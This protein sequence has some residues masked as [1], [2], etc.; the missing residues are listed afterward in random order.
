VAASEATEGS[1][2][3]ITR[4]GSDLDEARQQL[5]ATTE[6]LLTV[7]Q[8]ASD[9]AGVLR[10]VVESARRLIRAEIAQIHLIEDRRYRLA[11]STGHSKE[12]LDFVADHPIALDRQTLIGR[13]GVD[14][15]AQQIADVL[16]D[17][18][19]G[20]RDIQEVGGYRSI[21]GV[22]M[23][24]DDEVVGVLSAWRNEV[25]PFPAR[26]IEV[27]TTFAAQAAI[28]IRNAELVSALEARGSELSAKVEQLEALGE[29]GQAVTSSLDL[30]QVLTKIVTH[31][32]ELT[33]A[34]GGSVFEFDEF[35]E[36][37]HVRTTYG[38]SAD[39]AEALRVIHMKL[40][41]TLVGRAALERK[42][43]QIPD[44]RLVDCDPHLQVLLEG[45]W[46]SVIA[47]PILRDHQIIGAL[48][49]RRKSV[50][51]F[52]D[53]AGE[54][55]ETFAGQSAVAII[56]ARLFA[57]LERKSAQLEV[58]SR[59]KSEFLASMSHELR[60]PLNAVIGF[61]DVLLERLYG[62]INE[63][64][65]EYL[66]D[67][68]SS[69]RHLLEILNDILDISKIEADRLELDYARFD[70]RLLLE[71]CLQMVREG[72]AKKGLA[73]SLVVD[74]NVDT[75]VADEL[76]IRQVV[77][78]LLSNAVKFSRTRIDVRAG[79][80]VGHLTV[81]VSDDGPGIALEYQSLIFEAFQ[82]GKR[83]S[84]EE[85]TGLGLTVSRQLVEKHGGS[86][87]VE[88]ELGRGSTFTFMVPT[89]PLYE[90]SGVPAV[91]LPMPSGPVVVV[92]ED[93]PR[94]LEL[95]CL[96]VRRLGVEYLTARDGRA[97]LELIRRVGPTAVILDIQLPVLDGWDLLGV[98]KGDPATAKIP[99]VVVSMLDERGRGLALGAAEYLVKPVRG[100][101][102][103]AALA[104]VTGLPASGRKLVFIGEDTEVL[105]LLRAALEPEGW[106]VAGA[107][108]ES[109]GLRLLREVQPAV[110]LLDLLGTGTSGLPMVD[111]V[112]SD[113][114][115]AGVPIIVLTSQSMTAEEK[116]RLRGQIDLVNRSS[117]FDVS[118]LVEV[119]NRAMH[120]LVPTEDA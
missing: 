70:V 32:V 3:E 93:D 80:D 89:E 28:V 40:R 100:E 24:L 77:L 111:S 56:N 82:Q 67:I 22:P 75:V 103:R 109:E 37:F 18:E 6:V 35:D 58:A 79:S 15:R 34:D 49:I 74:D 51:G 63:K 20:R 7:G 12:Y 2:G 52:A 61:S 72:A 94:S 53:E 30:D 8:S 4:L 59:H 45:G 33:D 114:S 81:Q 90:S 97:G 106:I 96:H 112:R 31:A 9:S 5:A 26:A 25:D 50:G 99:V 84:R 87:T 107:S 43:L 57:E 85:G 120:R 88:S 27:L 60:T 13:V 98:L 47:V 16:A 42:W 41:E 10:S 11:S 91:E 36:E 113:P 71:H 64:Q 92:V 14:R 83:P 19:Y 86:L 62:D 118:A 95:L 119:V 110:V 73:I 44:L 76:R 101:D 117:D 55:L 46:I 29:I 39:T 102:V 115:T 68:L 17:S 38:T 23:I 21:L 65:E 105:E 78:N 54:L 108:T 104:R 69:G 116:E 1:D 66:R 48:V